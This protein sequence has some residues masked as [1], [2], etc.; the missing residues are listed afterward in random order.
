MSAKMKTPANVK[1]R[2]S[3]EA[4]R[5]LTDAFATIV[6]LKKHIPE[7]IYEEFFAFLN[8]FAVHSEWPDN[9]AAIRAIYP[10]LLPEA[11]DFAT[12]NGEPTVQPA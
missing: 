10:T 1:A 9:P 7:G 12:R 11:F 4:Y 3:A 2:E 6:E 8:Q 5:R